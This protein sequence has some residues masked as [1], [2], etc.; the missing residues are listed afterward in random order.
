MGVPAYVVL[1]DRTLG[2]LASR[3]PTSPGALLDVP[4]IG[5]SKLERFGGELLELLAETEAAAGG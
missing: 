3:R 5:P 1:S 2:E 4:G